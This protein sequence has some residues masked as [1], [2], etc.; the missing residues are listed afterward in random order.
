MEKLN[1]ENK[2]TIYVSES[3]EQLD[4]DFNMKFVL[5]AG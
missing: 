2:E 3:Y 4:K 1:N 5:G